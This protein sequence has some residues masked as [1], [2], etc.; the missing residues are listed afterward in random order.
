L[1]RAALSV[2]FEARCWKLEVYAAGLGDL[3]KILELDHQLAAFRVS[4]TRSIEPQLGLSR[5]PINPPSPFRKLALDRHFI[6][7]IP[8]ELRPKTKTQPLGV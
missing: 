6:G 1:H 2:K 4:A 7:A 3:E 5:A 8:T